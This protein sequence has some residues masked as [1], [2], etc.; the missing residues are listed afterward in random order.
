MPIKT[1]AEKYPELE[2]AADRITK[3]TVE[4]INAESRGIK[5]EMPYKA[6]GILERVAQKL[7]ELV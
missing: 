1:F 3:K 5:S 6:Q 2:E 7:E 4:L